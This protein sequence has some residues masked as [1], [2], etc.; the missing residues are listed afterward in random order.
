MPVMSDPS[1]AKMDI[2]EYLQY[3]WLFWS[4]Q[5]IKVEKLQ[6]KLSNTVIFEDL[7]DKNRRN[8]S[9]TLNIKLV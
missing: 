8:S 6:H 3:I 5:S 1:A 2:Q 7:H 4:S 9:I